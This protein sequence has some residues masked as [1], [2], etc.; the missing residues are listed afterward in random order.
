MPA[1]YCGRHIARTHEILPS[2]R[3]VLQTLPQLTP[4]G[5]GFTAADFEENDNE[6]KLYGR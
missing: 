1:D 5:Q 3:T 2:T 4:Q 6:C